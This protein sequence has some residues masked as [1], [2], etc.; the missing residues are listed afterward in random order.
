MLAALG[1]VYVH[2]PVVEVIIALSIVFVGVEL[3]RSLNG[4]EG[5]TV[6]YPWFIS[7]AF[8][9][10]HGFGFAGALADV[11]LPSQ[12]IPLSLLLFNIGVELGQLLFVFAMLVLTWIFN[13]TRTQL[14]KWAHYLPPYAIGSFAAFW[15]IERAL[16]IL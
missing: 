15:F 16:T 13:R 10:L 2:P 11:G 5:I 1:W 9:L 14:P 7:F 12:D 8:G 3:V 6:K 4:H